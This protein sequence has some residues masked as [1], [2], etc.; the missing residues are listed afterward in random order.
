MPTT[1]E[2]VLDL[3]SSGPPSEV[4]IA[5]SLI[6][7]IN[8]LFREQMGLAGHDSKQITKL[9][10]K[11]RDA[12]R[13]SPPWKPTSSRV[14]GRP[15]DGSDGNRINRWLLDPQHKFYADEITATLVEVKYYLQALSME[16]APDF[17]K[18]TIQAAFGWLIEHSVLPGA[19]FD[20]IQLVPIQLQPVIENARI[21]QSGHLFP[22]DR[23]GKHVPGNAFLMLAR[24]NQIQGNL[25]LDELVDLMET[26]V[27]RHRGKS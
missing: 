13:R 14:P 10:T 24:S 22:L 5:R 27:G 1:L 7:L 23:G 12:G 16:G 20:P 6:K 9:T 3:A 26:I 4:E 11:F 21:I 25:T 18:G 17:E 15:Q 8:K 19:Y 2:L